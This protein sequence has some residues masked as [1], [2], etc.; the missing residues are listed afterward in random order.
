MSLQ[1]TRYHWQIQ[2]AVTEK[3]LTTE[4]GIYTG[5]TNNLVS[6]ANTNS[7]D[8]TMRQSQADPGLATRASRATNSRQCVP[9]N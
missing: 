1:K 4:Y 8:R 6:L 2:I 7:C 9:L 3:I 5:A